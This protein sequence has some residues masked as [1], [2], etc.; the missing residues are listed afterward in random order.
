MVG[1]WRVE[2]SDPVEPFCIERHTAGVPA[3]R[4]GGR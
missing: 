2:R 4:M 1:W 3:R